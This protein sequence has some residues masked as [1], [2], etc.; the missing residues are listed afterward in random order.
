[1]KKSVYA[2]TWL[3]AGLVTVLTLL[4]AA[5]GGGGGGDSS[6]GSS[7][8]PPPPPPSANNAPSISGSP[9]TSWIAGTVY[10]FVPTASDPDGDAMTFSI[11]NQPA[12]MSFNQSTGALSGVPTTNDLGMHEGISISVSDGQESADLPTF[13]IE[14]LATAT[15]A[16]TLNWTPPMASADGSSLDDMAGYRIRWGTQSGE[17]PNMEEV[18][19]PGISSFM[20]EGLAP[21]TYFLTV[22]AVD[23]ANNESTPSNEAQG[24]AQ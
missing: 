19:S 1:M 18:L 13:G 3:P 8:P 5:C 24:V 15:S 9:Q 21:G 4:L 23:L 2:R 6:T 20:L 22:S 7:P 10:T 12:W 16:L 14:V 17:L 11:T